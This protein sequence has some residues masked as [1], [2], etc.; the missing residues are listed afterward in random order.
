MYSLDHFIHPLKGRQQQL[1]QGP[2]RVGNGPGS[3]QAPVG[4]D[5]LPAIQARA[6]LSALC[7]DTLGVKLT[8][9]FSQLLQNAQESHGVAVP[10]PSVPE[11]FEEK[12]ALG[13][14]SSLLSSGRTVLSAQQYRALGEGSVCVPS[15]GADSLIMRFSC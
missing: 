1:P 14:G 6:C 4:V 10:T 3:R 15:S 9:P 13:K 2:P 5:K 11:N 8:A 7:S 12:A